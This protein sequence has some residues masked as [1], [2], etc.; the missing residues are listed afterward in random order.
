LYFPPGRGE[1]GHDDTVPYECRSSD[2]TRVFLSGIHSFSHVSHH[3]ITAVFYYRPSSLEAKLTSC[4]LSPPPS[5]PHGAE[6]G[7]NVCSQSS[8]FLYLFSSNIYKQMRLAKDR[9]RDHSAKLPSYWE[10]GNHLKNPWFLSRLYRD[11]YLHGHVR[12]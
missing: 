3:A 5:R 10:T 2:G 7:L 4:F 9:R 1:K 11:G 6:P 12:I 8:E